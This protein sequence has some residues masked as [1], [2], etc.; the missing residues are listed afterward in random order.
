MVTD[1]FF[2]DL[3]SGVG[4]GFDNLVPFYSSFKDEAFTNI[5]SYGTGNSYNILRV[6]QN[7]P[8]VV[9]SGGIKLGL[10]FNKKHLIFSKKK[11]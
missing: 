2:I 10:R 5:T 9:F 1:N 6:S 11:K 8:G 7:S 3:Y 4:Y